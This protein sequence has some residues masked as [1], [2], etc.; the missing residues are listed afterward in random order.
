MSPAAGEIHFMYVYICS[1]LWTSILS[2]KRGKQDETTGVPS[3]SDLCVWPRIYNV[4]VCLWKYISS[5]APSWT[6]GHGAAAASP[7]LS[8]CWILHEIFSS[9]SSQLLFGITTHPLNLMIK[10]RVLCQSLPYLEIRRK[11]LQVYH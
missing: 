11:I 1:H 3:V 8:G 5:L 10:I 7:C 9:D 2:S 6:Q 4:C